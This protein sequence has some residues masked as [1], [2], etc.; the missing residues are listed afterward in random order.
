MYVIATSTLKINT[1][2]L[3][4]PLLMFPLMVYVR[5]CYMNVQERTYIGKMMKIIR[6]VRLGL[7]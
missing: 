7:R 5:F 1:D 6:A 4:Y 2:T 3:I